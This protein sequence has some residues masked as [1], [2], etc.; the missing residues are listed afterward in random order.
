M[1]IDRKRL[2]RSVFMSI[3]N[4]SASSH[5]LIHMLVELLC[6]AA[7]F[8]YDLNLPKFLFHA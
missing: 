7:G 1:Y 8:R 4:V 5:A 6:M 2:S 3:L